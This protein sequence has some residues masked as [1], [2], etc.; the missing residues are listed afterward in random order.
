MPAS[1]FGL[2]EAIN[3]AIPNAD[4]VESE[5]FSADLKNGI[6][7][8]GSELDYNGRLIFDYYNSVSV[9]PELT[10]IVDRANWL[11]S[12]YDAGTLMI[13]PAEEVLK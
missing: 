1:R 5:K 4:A 10:E 11:V 7:I 9:H 3:D 8:R 13:W 12:H 2:I 6:W